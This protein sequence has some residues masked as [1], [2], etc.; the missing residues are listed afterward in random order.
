MGKYSH[1]K[2]FPLYVEEGILS[3]LLTLEGGGEDAE[4]VA[5]I[6]KGN[7]TGRGRGELS[8]RGRV[9]L[10]G[11]DRGCDISIYI[12]IIIII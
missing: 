12:I 7:P 10:V 2:E 11:D 9:Y 4:R 5:K 8:G 1:I 3:I 6:L